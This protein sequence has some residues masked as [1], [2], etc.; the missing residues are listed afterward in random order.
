MPNF[1]HFLPVP[2]DES[3]IYE[4]YYSPLW[5]TVSV[6]LAI[7]ASYASLNASTRIQDHHDPVAK[8]YWSII[9]AFTLGIGIWSMHFLGMLA[10]KLP[11]VTHY[12]LF[13]TLMSMV[14]A[15][16]SSGVALGV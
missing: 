15:I 3:L 11:C 8:L 13:I 14:P 12:D 2:P 10:L 5:V 9:S 1:L 16:L 4:G 6:F 7:L